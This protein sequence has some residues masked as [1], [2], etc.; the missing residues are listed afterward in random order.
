[1]LG[2]EGLRGGEGD[3]GEREGRLGYFIF[4]AR[5]ILAGL[6]S[7]CGY[8]DGDIF[9]FILLVFKKRKKDLCDS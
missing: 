2:G 5:S 7:W 6:M 4:G 3:R 8:G 9:S 1:M